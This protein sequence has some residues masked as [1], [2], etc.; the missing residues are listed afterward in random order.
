M[1]PV[2]QWWHES[3]SLFPQG[4][5][6]AHTWSPVG[7]SASESAHSVREGK[8]RQ[9]PG[10]G[11]RR[12]GE[13]RWLIEQPPKHSLLYRH[14]QNT[15]VR[16][17]LRQPGHKQQPACAA[18]GITSECYVGIWPLGVTLRPCSFCIRVLGKVLHLLVST[19]FPQ[20]PSLCLC[21]ST[22]RLS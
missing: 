14:P 15:A 10:R 6:S 12:R 17:P 11:G 20:G 19:L 9:E 8:V 5:L 21:I 2:L 3:F 4:P 16:E 18:P 7:P 13:G 22:G 1:S